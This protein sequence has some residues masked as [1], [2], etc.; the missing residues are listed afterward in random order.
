MKTEKS[1]RSRKKANRLI[2]LLESMISYV[3]NSYSHQ[4]EQNKGF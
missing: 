4:G 1:K 3:P 2:N